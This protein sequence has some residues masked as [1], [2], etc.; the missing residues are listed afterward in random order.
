MGPRF[1]EA[2]KKELEPWL[3]ERTQQS[4]GSISAEHG[5]GFMK[6]DVLDYAK[7]P[8]AIALI[9]NAMFSGVF[10]A[11]SFNFLSFEFGKSIS[12]R[13]TIAVMSKMSIKLRISL[14]F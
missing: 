10:S 12:D 13:G 5:V 6:R 14:G 2:V 11:R 9:I 7:S 8:Q 3:W 4:R 1:Q